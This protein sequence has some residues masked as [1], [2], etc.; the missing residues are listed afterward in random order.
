MK[1]SRW[2]ALV[3]L[4]SALLLVASA[5][6]EDDDAGGPG[7]FTPG[8]L[9]AVEIGPGEPLEI[10]AVQAISG[11]VASLGEDQVRAIE[12]AIDDLGGEFRGHPI[13]LS[14]ED[15]QC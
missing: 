3:S 12:I 11:D 1:K 9:G 5:C 14:T 7:A 15:G 2:L 6:G 4:L 10:G 8:E 13:E